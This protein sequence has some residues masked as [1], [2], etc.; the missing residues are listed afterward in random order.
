MS[1]IPIFKRVSNATFVKGSC[2]VFIR[3]NLSVYTTTSSLV[4]FL[5]S[6]CLF[7]DYIKTFCKQIDYDN[8]SIIDPDDPTLSDVLENNQSGGPP[9]IEVPINPDPTPTD[10]IDP[11]MDR[12]GRDDKK[13]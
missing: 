5:L 8:T 12:F 7:D 10:R 11:F 3:I 9:A 13:I 4:G 1:F 2:I 6:G